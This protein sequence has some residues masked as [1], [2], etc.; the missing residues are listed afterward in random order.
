MAPHSPCLGGAL[1]RFSDLRR[2]VGGGA[3]AAGHSPL[4]DVLTEVFGEGAVLVILLFLMMGS[5]FIAAG[6]L[7]GRA[8]YGLAV[9]WVLFVLFLA[10]APRIQ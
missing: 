3:Y 5:P 4:V 1:L 9:A 8:R 10:F 7:F 6:A 2:D